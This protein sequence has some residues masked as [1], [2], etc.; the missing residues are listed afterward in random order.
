[1]DIIFVSFIFVLGLI[2]GSFL[3]VVIL[4]YNTGKSLGGR[5]GCL[6]CGKILKF[7]E[8]VPLI[9]Y[10]YQK[11]KC[12]KCYSKISYQYPLV[13]FFTA[14][15]FVFVYLN[16]A[17]NST[18]FIAELLFGMVIFSILIVIFAY[19]IHHK[20]IPNGLAYAFAII[21]L[22]H[23]VIV[24]GFENLF[25]YPGILD[26]FAGVIFFI[27]FYLLWYFS[28]GEWI[29]LGDGKLAVGMGALLGFVNGLSA[30]VLAFWIGAVFSL[31]LL[32]ILRLKDKGG[33]ITMKSEIP[34]APFL[35]IG[36][37]ISFFFEFD[38]LS[39]GSLLY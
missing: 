32:L 35:I 2:I 10:I 19:D 6:F 20:I 4:R 5:S 21:S 25:R 39:I 38:V 7:V 33:H 36:T 11:G 22:V 29:G 12:T 13:E 23:L 28:K 18:I 37:F 3:N 27:P 26:L 16:I 8:L 34:F 17:A 31:L 30:L 1:M 9:S 15:T 24:N 14:L